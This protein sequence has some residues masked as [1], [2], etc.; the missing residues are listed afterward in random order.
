[1][2]RTGTGKRRFLRGPPYRGAVCSLSAAREVNPMTF[3]FD[4][5]GIAFFAAWLTVMISLPI[6]VRWSRR[7][8]LVDDPGH[9]KIHDKPVS[10]AGGLAVMT[11]IMLPVIIAA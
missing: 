2:P 8:G 7:A 5:Y 10:L 9:R 4:I 3:P 6:W 11:G 1:M